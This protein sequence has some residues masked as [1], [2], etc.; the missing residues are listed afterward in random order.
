MDRNECE[1]SDQTWEGELIA[2]GYP[3][4]MCNDLRVVQKDEKILTHLLGCLASQFC[5]DYV[6]A[7]KLPSMMR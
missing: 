5:W 2:H 1:F 3:K 6:S 4:V 7:D